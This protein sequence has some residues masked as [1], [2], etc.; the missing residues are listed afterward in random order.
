MTTR[1]TLEIGVDLSGPTIP[2]K[3]P[4]K[5]I[6]ALIYADDDNDALHRA[7]RVAKYKFG[8]RSEVVYAHIIDRLPRRPS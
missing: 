4:D 6:T 2:G 3:L 5:I 7:N 1:Y 8:L